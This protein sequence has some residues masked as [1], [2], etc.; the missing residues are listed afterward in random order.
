MDEINNQLSLRGFTWRFIPPAAPHFGG[1][2]E[3]K[4]QS[5]KRGLNVALS[6]LFPSEETFTTAISHVINIINNTPISEISTD[7]T[8]ARALTPNDLILGRNNSTAV[9][10]ENLNLK[11]DRNSWKTSHAIA[12]RFWVRWVKECRP[13]LQRRTKWHNDHNALKLQQNDVVIIA[14]ETSKRN[15]WPLGIIV[16]THPGKDN[17]VR[18]ATV[19]TS[20]GEFKRPVVKLILIHRPESETAS[21]G[22]E[23]VN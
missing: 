22:P 19:R 10:V 5:V 8:E 6:E 17:K 2:Y 20:N 21:E 1:I 14:D 7:A 18:A 9:N 4:V 13:L 16:A 23:N 12:D 11:L 15:T 3:R